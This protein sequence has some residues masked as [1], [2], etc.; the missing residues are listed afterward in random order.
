MENR[1]IVRYHPR[2]V[3]RAGRWNQEHAWR[4]SCHVEAARS[5]PREDPE[6]EGQPERKVLGGPDEKSVRGAR[7]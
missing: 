6:R 4:W 5:D 2:V 1:L 7:G 3:S